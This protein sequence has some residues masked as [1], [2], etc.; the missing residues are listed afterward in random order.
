MKKRVLTALLVTIAVII[1]FAACAEAPD[2][3]EFA[4][5]T[6]VLKTDGAV[7]QFT[8]T[9]DKDNTFS[10][11]EGH[12]SDYIGI[13]TWSIDGARIK[14]ENN[15]GTLVNYFTYENGALYY[16]AE[17]SSGFTNSTVNDGDKFAELTASSN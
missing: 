9:I 16:S 12:K 17:G 6:Y 10:Y 7:G 4:G 1:M 13:G 11:L 8:V 14:L 3:A 2:P 15:D 5:K